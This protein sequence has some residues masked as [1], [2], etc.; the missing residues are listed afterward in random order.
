MYVNTT[1]QRKRTG[2]GKEI[3]LKHLG[4]L[5][6]FK[7]TQDLLLLT[8]YNH[9]RFE[10]PCGAKIISHSARM[11]T[12]RRTEAACVDETPIINLKS[13]LLLNNVIHMI[14]VPTHKWHQNLDATLSFCAMTFQVKIPG[15]GF[16]VVILDWTK[17]CSKVKKRCLGLKKW[18]KFKSW[19]IEY[20]KFNEFG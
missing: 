2:R 10:R 14:I 6:H 15:C 1:R 5:G 19:L 13:P 16:L 17:L 9:W 11:R 4:D 7:E 20:I 3:F 12:P 8:Y 18:E